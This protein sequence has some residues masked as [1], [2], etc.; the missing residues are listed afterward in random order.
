VHG[1]VPDES[2]EVVVLGDEVG[3]AVHFHQHADLAAGVDVGAD[4]A[5]GGRAACLLG[6]GSQTLG[7]EVV[8]RLLVI[9][10]GFGQGFFAVHQACAGCL[11]QFVNHC[12]CNAHMILHSRPRLL[13][14]GVS[15]Y[16]FECY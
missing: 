13:S 4:H 6:S 9:A 16:G 14:A 2:L 10:A 5:F 1:D 15:S 12:R 8:D 11:S 3:L 7:A